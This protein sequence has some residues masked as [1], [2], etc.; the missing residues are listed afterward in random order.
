[1][2]IDFHCHTK[3]TKKGEAPSRN[4]P[5]PRY[6]CDQVE[7]ANVKMLAIT[8]HNSFDLK[9]FKT[10][11]KEAK[12][13]IIIFPGVELDI[14]GL[15]GERGHLVFFYDNRKVDE[16]NREIEK[17]LNSKDADS[18]T[19]DIDG[20]ISFANKLNTGII[21]A[22]Y[23][24][25]DALD[26]KS[27]QKIRDNLNNK[28]RF[29]FEPSNYR[30]LGIMVNN[31]FRVLMGSDI[32]DWSEYQKQQFAS[33][34]L[35]IDSYDMLF[36]FIK[37]DAEVVESVLNK[38]RYE[39]ILISYGRD[40]KKE[41]CIYQD[42]NIIFGEKGSGKTQT[43]NEIKR[44]FDNLNNS[45]SYYS[46]QRVDDCIKEKLSISQE[47]RK[48]SYYN[49]GTY[50]DELEFLRNWDS[51]KITKFDDYSEHIRTASLNA[52]KAKMHI[53][54]ITD[55]GFGKDKSILKE[56]E[57]H[58]KLFD[59]L[60][61]II[62]K[63]TPNIYLKD[64]DLNALND[65]IKKLHEKI[66]QKYR[67]EFINSLGMTLSKQFVNKMKEITDRNTDSRSLPSTTGFT[68]YASLL[69][70][71]NVVA[72]KILGI[73]DILIDDD[74]KFIGALD[75]GKRLYIRKKVQGLSNNSKS[76]DGFDKI[77]ILRQIRTT[78]VKIKQCLFNKDLGDHI[79]KYKDL[80]NCFDNFDIDTMIGI[81]KYFTLED[82]RKYTPS[83]GEETM[84]ALDEALNEDSDVYILDEPEK[85]LGNSYINDIIVKRI[86][87]LTKLKKTIVIVTH[88]ANIAIRTLPYQTILKVYDGDYTTY[89][90][91]LYSGILRNLDSG[92]EKDWR[93]ESIRIL[94]GGKEAFNERGDIYAQ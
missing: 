5:S 47:E 79:L 74:P 50:K 75:N 25:S 64:I 88:N 43:L 24:K 17:L 76:T 45:I 92:N 10:I 41:V 15:N 87:Y 65:S 48:S 14:I 34:K 31:N 2:L 29:F 78:L 54:S 77:T 33:I 86:N 51:T 1:M 70:K 94:E 38:L 21:M 55:E 62:N 20:F 80:I 56:V 49:I 61:N 93:E 26:Y 82:G 59:E 63:M 91:S 11:Q 69:F 73:E 16:F 35:D 13:K 8:N 32:Q 39:K 71:T 18:F 4:I 36:R 40:S 66:L 67:E 46:P 52:N 83:T 7:N 81:S 22:H 68:S 19:I 84:I 37:K 27:L 3:A 28:F 30:T 42:V 23:H 6:F 72:N 53:L 90:G 44:Y 9:Q 85:S 58:L 57:E 89:I 12:N 60:R